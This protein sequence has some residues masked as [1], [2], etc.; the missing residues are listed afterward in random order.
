MKKRSLTTKRFKVRNSV[1]KD[2]VPIKY[3]IRDKF[4]PIT[5]KLDERCN[6]FWD[7]LDEL[8]TDKVHPKEKRYVKM[9]RNAIKEHHEKMKDDPERLTTNFLIDITGC[10]C[11][12]KK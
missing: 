7:A 2:R 3:E 10:K 11:E 12:R 6:S 1:I 4:C 5:T 8:N 9:C